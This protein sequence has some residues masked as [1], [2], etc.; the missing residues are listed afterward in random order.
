MQMTRSLLKARCATSSSLL[1]SEFKPIQNNYR[2]GCLPSEWQT[3]HW[4]SLLV[5]CQ[6]F[7]HSVNPK[8][9]SS[10]STRKSKCGF[11]S[12]QSAAK[13]LTL[14]KNVILVSALS[15]YQDTFY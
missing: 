10:V 6:D 13:K 11:L 12:L 14:N 8:G 7:Y 9:L 4:P 2:S 1:G 5:L 15:S 3:T